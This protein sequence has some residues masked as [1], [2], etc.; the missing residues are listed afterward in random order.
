MRKTAKSR[1]VARIFRKSCAKKTFLRNIQQEFQYKI[2][3][4]IDLE[5]RK[6]SRLEIKRVFLQDNPR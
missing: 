4:R 5:L 6:D 2:D 1:K 3:F